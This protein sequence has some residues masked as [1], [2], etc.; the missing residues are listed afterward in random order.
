MSDFAKAHKN[1][2]AALS[3]L[4]AEFKVYDHGKLPSEIR[5]PLDFAGV[6]GYP[7]QRIT[8]TLF[9]LS[10][11]R[12]VAA[13]AVCSVDRRLNF[14]SVADVV[15]AKRLEVASETE[16]HARTGYPRNGVSPLGLAPDIAVIV[17]SP[18]FEYP[19]LL[20]GGG[21]TGI[22]IEL[23]PADLLRTSSARL[24]RIAT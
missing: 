17:D 6:L 21:A 16:L 18:L 7:V 8:K 22:E 14:K 5:S 13:A 12:Q 19:T 1:V 2:Q 11:D 20:I 24:Q 9:L 10:H 15:G 3:G 4:G 23:S